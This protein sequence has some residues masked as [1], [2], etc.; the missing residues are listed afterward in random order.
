MIYNPDIHHRRSIRLKGY[1]YSQI[2]AYFITICT[3]NRECLFGEIVDGAMVLNLVGEIIQEQWCT[4]PQRYAQVK[5][6]E[7][8]VMPN[9]IHGIITVGAPLAGAHGNEIGRA[10][11]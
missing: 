3:Q 2:G 11:V 7:F 9:H 5:S 8:V 6:D 4:I 1:D 10:H